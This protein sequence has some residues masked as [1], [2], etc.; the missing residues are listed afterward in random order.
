ML[1]VVI[2]DHQELY[3]PGIVNVLARADGVR[4]VGQPQSPTEL[5]K[6]LQEAVPRV[7]ILSTNFLPALL[8]LQRMLNHRKTKLL[9]LA[10]END[11]TDY[12]QW[13][14]VHGIVYRSMDEP[15]LVDAVR[16]VA[17]GELFVQ[18][19]ISDVTDHISEVA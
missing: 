16:R 7:L 15:T 11:Q 9:L 17:R 4:I 3:R 1:E 14:R 5:L 8:Y 2:V 19:R 13:L 6:V 10:E 18:E 12:T